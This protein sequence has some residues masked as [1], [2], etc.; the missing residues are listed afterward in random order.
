MEDA[1]YSLFFFAA[2]T[3][4]GVSLRRARARDRPDVSS[5]LLAR[6]DGKGPDGMFSA[7]QS[8]PESPGRVPT[9]GP[10]V[11]GRLGAVNGR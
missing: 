11:S 3:G 1:L 10:A 9:A 6:P 7:S 4:L 8:A 2:A 5:S